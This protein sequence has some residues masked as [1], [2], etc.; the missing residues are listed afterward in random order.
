MEIVY[1][2]DNVLDRGLVERYIRTTPH[3][4]T[5]VSKLEELDLNTL[6]ADLNLVDINIGDKIL[7]GN[8]SRR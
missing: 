2:E 5:A 6:S 7:V 1:I 3:N 8:L 4:L